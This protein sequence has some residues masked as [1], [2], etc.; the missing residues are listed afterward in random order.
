ML[1][2]P[3]PKG[4]LWDVVSLKEEASRVWGD[5]RAIRL[6]VIVNILLGIL[7]VTALQRVDWNRTETAGLDRKILLLLPQ[8]P[9]PLRLSLLSEGAA[10]L[11]WHEQ[12]RLARLHLSLPRSR[13]V[14]TLVP[15][16]AL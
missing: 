8:K 13:G 5:F 9:G 6:C 3:D 10:G 1:K 2:L 4:G 14:W 7:E 12:E 16:P 15:V 11:M